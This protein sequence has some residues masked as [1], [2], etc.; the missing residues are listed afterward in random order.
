MRPKVLHENILKE[1]RKTALSLGG[2]QHREVGMNVYN[3]HL[4]R[5]YN[6]SKSH[7]RKMVK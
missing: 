6:Y 7:L 3:R 2:M 4:G 1:K 5:L